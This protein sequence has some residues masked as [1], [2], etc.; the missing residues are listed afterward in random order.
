MSE[1]AREPEAP[2]RDGD[3]AA[4]AE[5]PA[6]ADGPP[7]KEGLFA[8]YRRLVLEY[9]VWATVINL[10]IFGV[11]ILCFHT[12]IR[13]GF[14]VEGA[15]TS[16]G[17]W[18]AAYAAAQVIKPFRLMLVVFLT[19][20]VARWWRRRGDEPESAAPAGEDAADVAAERP[21]E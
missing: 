20:L 8:R 11:A 5:V 19:P 15:E 16:A 17:T 1:V 21:P 4:E 12:A 10:T 13:F 18:V 6:E 9:G 7:E 14:E 3:V 2:R